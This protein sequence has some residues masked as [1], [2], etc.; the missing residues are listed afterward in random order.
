MRLSAALI[1]FFAVGATAQT[2]TLSDAEIQG[3]QLAQQIISAKPENPAVLNGLMKIKDGK[4]INYQ[5]CFSSITSLFPANGHWQTDYYFGS[6]TTNTSHVKGPLT[7]IT[8]SNEMTSSNLL[9]VKSMVSIL[10]FDSEECPLKYGSGE[11]QFYLSGERGNFT[12]STNIDSWLS[13]YKESDFSFADLGLE[14]FHWP[15]QKV[16]PKTTNLKRGRDY[17]LLESTNPNPSTNGYSRVLSWID[18]ET[19]GIL[20]AEAYDAD[21]KLL[22]EFAPKSFKKINGQWELQEMEIRNVQ[23]GSRTRLEFDLQK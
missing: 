18:K 6:T 23:T 22:K 5:Y 16:L 10:H 19:G 17:T 13:I 20:E 14:F 21:G 11:F 2:N 7:I 1:L 12:Y 8:P 4:G 3:R 15:Q 9:A